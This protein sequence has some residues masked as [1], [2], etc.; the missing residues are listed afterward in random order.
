M[1]K[2]LVIGSINVDLVFNT[3]HLPLKGET[4]FAKHFETHFGG[5]GANQDFTAGRLGADVELMGVVGDDD[6]GRTSKHNLQHNGCVAV[7]RIAMTDKFTTGI[8]NIVVAKNGD[9]HI[10]VNSGAN[11]HFEPDYIDTI[12]TVIDEKKIIIFQLKITIEAVETLAN[13]AKDNG[14]TI[15]LNA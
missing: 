14:T 9:N 10:I 7:D 3:E 4:L 13:Y 8:A 2:I 1:K 11:F 6:D 15:I 12:K 5:K